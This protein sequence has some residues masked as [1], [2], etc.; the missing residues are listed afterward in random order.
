[1]TSPDASTAG[2]LPADATGARFPKYYGVKRELLELTGSMAPGTPVP[3]ERELAHR[4]GTSRTTIRQALAELVIEGR[5][6]RMQGK[7]TFVAQPKVAQLLELAGYTEEMRAHGL[8]PRTQILDTGYQAADQE[9]ALL[10]GI[11]PGGRVLRI[12]RLRFADD[13]PMAIGAA[14]LPARRFPGLRRKLDR[15]PSL[16]ETLAS[17]YGVALAQAEETIETVLATPEDA[18]L[19]AVDAGLP[20][21]L[22]SRQAFDTSGTPVEWSQSWYRGD[23]YKF[24][25]RT[26]RPAQA[27]Q[28]SAT[29]W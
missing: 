29:S 24:V 13:E 26:R 6:R 4:Y 8:S 3:G 10:L 18:R 2:G 14:Y 28:Q 5:L 27:A 7:G 22:L 16:Y 12:S 19:L 11:R 25:T 9:L 15:S 21:L 20:L 17:A 23:R 1:V